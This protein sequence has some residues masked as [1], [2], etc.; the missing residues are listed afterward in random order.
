[1]SLEILQI[2]RVLNKNNK[3][4]Y[5]DRS[6]SEMY[7]VEFEFANNVRDRGVIISLP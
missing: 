2:L 7:A 4:L 6:A 3:V 5:Y 1:M